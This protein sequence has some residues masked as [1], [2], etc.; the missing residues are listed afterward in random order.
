MGSLELI[1]NKRDKEGKRAK[2]ESRGQKA[3]GRKDR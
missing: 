3:E 2:T 1:G